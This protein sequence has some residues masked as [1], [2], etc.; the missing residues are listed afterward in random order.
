MTTIDELM[1]K[2]LDILP[3]AVLDEDTTGEIIIATGLR[4][5]DDGNLE[6]IE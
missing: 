6:P 4:E 1:S 2:V 5:V 3:N